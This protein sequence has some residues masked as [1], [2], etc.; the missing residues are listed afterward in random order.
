MTARRL[1]NFTLPWRDPLMAFAPL[2][3]EPYALLLGPGGD[4]QSGRGR[5]SILLAQPDDIFEHNGPDA[6]SDLPSLPL[7]DGTTALPFIGGYAGLISY[8]FGA[9]LERVPRLRGS[10]WPDIAFGHYPCA[11]LFDHHEKVLHIVGPDTAK[12][13]N[14]AALL[15][16]A[17][18]PALPVQT[19]RHCDH[20]DSQNTVAKHVKS[21][22]D[23]IHQGDIFQANISQS[24]E[25]D[26]GE[27][28]NAYTYF[29][30]LCSQSP[31][32][33]GAFFRLNTARTLIS[34]SPEQFFALSPEGKVQTSPIK[35]TRP[36]S[37]EPLED[38]RLAKA[39]QQSAKDR[40]ENL[41]IVDLMRNDLSRVC[42][43]GS[44]QV[45][46]NCAL[47]SYANVHHLVST[48]EGQVR[49]HLGAIDILTACFPAGSITGAPKIRAMEIIAQIEQYPRGPYYGALGYIS[50][51]GAAEFNVLIRSAEHTHDK[52]GNHLYFRTGGGIVADSDPVMEVQEMLD[53]A[54]ALCRAAGAK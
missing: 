20:H 54:Q 2:S 17:P 14:F 28:E 24:F 18:L 12:A 3:N 11:A 50:H 38:Q 1:T 6:L 51:H 19:N 31:T 10:L 45:T 29:Q 27:T 21:V 25:I 44:V 48:I 33:Y 32:P 47:H 22:I 13:Q 39:L 9:A 37:H 23:L 35:G 16:D 46:Q 8:E 15:G 5:W 53:K 52:T 40:A 4:A 49:P 42:R 41:M 43:A 30:R 34:N 36:R 26:L 7:A